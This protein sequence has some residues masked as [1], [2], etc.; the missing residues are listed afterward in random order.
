MAKHAMLGIRAT[1]T[2]VGAVKRYARAEGKTMTELIRSRVVSPA[3]SY[4]P[5]QSRLQLQEEERPRRAG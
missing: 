1:K 5:R 4:D 3:L 2:E